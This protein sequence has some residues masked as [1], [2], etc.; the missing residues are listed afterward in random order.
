MNPL[1]KINKNLE[2]LPPHFK[3]QILDFTEFLLLKAKQVDV[4]KKNSGWSSLS[5]QS[6]MRDMEDESPEYCLPDLKENFSSDQS[7]KFFLKD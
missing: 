3:E 4:Y 7:E 1:E 2:V 5:L 6:A